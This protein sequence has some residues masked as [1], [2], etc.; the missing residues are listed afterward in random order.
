MPDKLKKRKMNVFV[1]E[2]DADE[3]KRIQK[4]KDLK[5]SQLFHLLMKSFK[6]NPL[7]E[8]GQI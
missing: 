8:G 3:F 2:F 6:E 5:Q 7:D 1:Y 4:N